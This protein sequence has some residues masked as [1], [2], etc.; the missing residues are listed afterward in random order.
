MG[1][2]SALV[3]ACR[4][5]EA[6][7]RRVREAAQSRGAGAADR[8]REASA[9]ADEELAYLVGLFQAHLPVLEAWATGGSRAA[10]E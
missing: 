9:R 7:S 4:K 1:P 6:S 8:R 10:R 5:W 3:E 2:I